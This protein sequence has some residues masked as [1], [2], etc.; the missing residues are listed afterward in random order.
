[1]SK[2]R[3]SVSVDAEKR[4]GERGYYAKYFYKIDIFI[5]KTAWITSDWDCVCDIQW[6]L[7]S[8]VPEFVFQKPVAFEI[9]EFLQDPKF[10]DFHHNMPKTVIVR[11]KF[12]SWSIY[13]TCHSICHLD[14]SLDHVPPISKMPLLPSY[15]TP[16]ITLK[17]DFMSIIL[18]FS[19]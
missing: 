8:C 9:A 16:R 5:I 12:H 1:M 17:F 10:R 14:V 13:D 18:R 2:Q 15:F 6:S 19:F 4:V 11:T 3:I 7:S